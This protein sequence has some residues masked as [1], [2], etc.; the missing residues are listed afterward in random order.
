M[1]FD[2][3]TT[4][5][6]SSS[7]LAEFVTAPPWM[8]SSISCTVAHSAPSTS[9]DTSTIESARSSRERRLI[10]TGSPAITATSNTPSIS[11]NTHCGPRRS[12]PGKRIVRTIAAST[13]PAIGQPRLADDVIFGALGRVGGRRRAVAPIGSRRHPGS[14]LELL[15]ERVSEHHRS[16]AAEAPFRWQ[17][18]TTAPR[19]PV[20]QGAGLRRP[21]RPRRRR[22]RAASGSGRRPGGT[23]SR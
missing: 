1:L 6:A 18:P 10:V 3:Q 5:P 11:G 7:S 14:I 19:S 20:Q 22:S 23:H 21:R 17:L 2:T 16:S 9:T 4:V 8:R 12:V 13:A 15:P